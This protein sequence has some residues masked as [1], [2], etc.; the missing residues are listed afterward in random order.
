[1]RL[2]NP[3]AV[4]QQTKCSMLPTQ[5]KEQTDGILTLLSWCKV[6]IQLKVLS[7]TWLTAI[8]KLQTWQQT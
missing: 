4:P 1:M 6:T 5:L 7:D 2:Q 3:K 8:L